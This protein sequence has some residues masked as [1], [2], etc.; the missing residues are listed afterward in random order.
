MEKL[1]ESIKHHEGCSLTPYEDTEGILTIGYGHNLRYGISLATANQILREDISKAIDSFWRLP[2]A[3]ILN[4]NTERRRVL[5]EMLYN[6]GFERMLEFRKMLGALEA[7]D[8][9]L[10]ADEMLDSKW[11]R[12]VGQRAKTLADTMRTGVWPW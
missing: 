7:S 9:Q 12:Q 5:V 3:V 2:F 4:C 6:L 1:I 10:A 11:A 8:F